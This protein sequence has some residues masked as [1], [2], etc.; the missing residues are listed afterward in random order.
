VISLE[1]RQL[2]R[3]SPIPLWF[4]IAEIL[5]QAIETGKVGPGERLDNEVEISERLG[6]S[7]PTVRQAIQ[8]LVHKDLVVRQRGVGTIVAARR[9]KRPVALTSLHDDLRATGRQP[10]TQVLSVTQR[11]A[12][13]EVADE[14]GIEPGDPVIALERLRSA[15][16]SPLALMSNFVPVA[17]LHR[18]LVAEELEQH[19]LYEVLRDQ[20]VRFHAAHQVIGARTA[21]ARESRLLR[22]ARGVTVLTMA[23]VASDVTGVVIA[24]SQHCSLARRYS[25]EISLSLK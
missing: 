9:I 7:R 15:E 12:E 16:G 6:V 2:D 24:V 10:S 1:A 22:S 4:Q 23:R 14:L 5:R 19:G 21:T 20:G 11:G 8:A 25:F 17:V 13:P 3:D 18:P